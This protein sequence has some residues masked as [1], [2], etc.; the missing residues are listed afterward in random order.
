MRVTAGQSHCRL[1]PVHFTLI[2]LLVV[3]SI[4]AILA[5]LLLPALATAREKGRQVVCLGNLKQWGIVHA[6]YSEE[7]NDMIV[8]YAVGAAV[9]AMKWW[10]E[11]IA[12]DVPD[13]EMFKCPG[14]NGATVG[15]GA[16]SNH[17]IADCNWVDKP[18][19]IRWLKHP[20][21]YMLM[22]DNNAANADVK[23]G[24]RCPTCGG[25]WWVDRGY[26]LVERHLR[27]M[28]ALCTDGHGE[29]YPYSRVRS[30]PSNPATGGTDIWAHYNTPSLGPGY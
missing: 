3:I 2:E 11:T 12:P 24:A 14:V 1:Q 29:W 20:E 19:R 23:G 8:P 13:K 7:N 15:Y 26:G 22:L 5:S 30:P 9:N 17:L 25:V 28:N 21:Q 18:T 27:G 16:C 6:V 10:Y 4:I